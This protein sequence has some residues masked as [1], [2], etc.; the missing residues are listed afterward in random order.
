MKRTLR[1]FFYFFLL[2]ATSVTAQQ[3]HGGLTGGLVA[4]QVAGDTYSG[5]DKAGLFVGGY[6]MLDLSQR[7]ALQM[8]LTY[9]QKGSR[10]NPD[11]ASN[12]NQYLFRTNYI[13]MPILYQFKT[14]KFRFYAGPSFGFLLSHYEESN[15]QLL[16]ENEGYN[17]PRAITLQLNIGMRFYITPKFGADFRTHNSL[18]NIR[19][20][21]A[22]GDV[23][24]IWGYG[25][26]HDALVL[27]LFYELR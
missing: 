16:H 17:K 26:F 23:W 24:R 27:S 2:S 6:V 15:Y 11:S 19:S 5:F 12:Y 9:F 8:E 4:S 18:I 25:Q 10:V 1:I 20:R 14:G 22:T 7:S 21:N 3:F 13:E